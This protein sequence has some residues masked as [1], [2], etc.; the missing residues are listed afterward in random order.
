L[1]RSNDIIPRK[2]HN[3][4]VLLELCIEKDNRFENIR[5][6]CGILNRFA[7]EIRYPHRIEIKIEDVNYSLNAVSRI[8]DLEP[9]KDLRT[10]I[11][12]ETE[13]RK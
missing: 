12:K 9:M 1:N 3:L 2:T 5:T 8:R 13:K 7:T 6:E 11:I 4:L 10:F